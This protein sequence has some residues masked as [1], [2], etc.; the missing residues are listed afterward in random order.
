MPPHLLRCRGFAVDDYSVTLRRLEAGAASTFAQS[1]FYSFSGFG[2]GGGG[3]S[4][5]CKC[6][7]LLV[8]FRIYP[9]VVFI[10]SKNDVGCLKVCSSYAFIDKIASG[11]CPRNDSGERVFTRSSNL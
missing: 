7:F 11:Y 3:D 1:V 5:G 9:F 10:T 2:R 8:N 6:P 4:T